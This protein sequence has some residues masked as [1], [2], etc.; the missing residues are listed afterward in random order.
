MQGRL[1][2]QFSENRGSFPGARS[3]RWLDQGQI[4]DFQQEWAGTLWWSVLCWADLCG[5][6]G[7]RGGGGMWKAGEFSAAQSAEKLFKAFVRFWK[8]YFWAWN[9][10][11]RALQCQQNELRPV[12]SASER[13]LVSLGSWTGNQRDTL[14]YLK[15]CNN[16]LY[17]HSLRPCFSKELGELM[18]C[19]NATWIN[20]GV[21]PAFLLPKH[22]AVWGEWCVRGDKMWSHLQLL[23]D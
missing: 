6:G 17:W 22:V 18:P 21:H 15:T 10:L 9:L 4:E 16:V 13:L 3:T 20:G 5:W 11:K 19:D 8:H 1:Q 23:L 7:M 12:L 2:E 14:L